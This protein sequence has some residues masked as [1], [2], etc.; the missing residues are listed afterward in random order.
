MRISLAVILLI[1]ILSACSGPV[2][3]TPVQPVNQS[4]SAAGAEAA[5]PAPEP[6][7]ITEPA[8]IPVT[9]PPADPAPATD[10]GPHPS[11]NEI[12]AVDGQ[13]IPPVLRVAEGTTV[14]IINKNSYPISLAPSPANSNGA[15]FTD[16]VTKQ[17]TINGARFN[18][19][20]PPGGSVSVTLLTGGHFIFTTE[21]QTGSTG[22]INVGG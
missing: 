20:L 7:Q 15:V 16:P 6:P 11:I 19:V 8:A 12:W 3:P 4:I 22:M 9:P 10:T 18:D 2:S 17:V 13:F 21:N 14:S 5:A 1:I